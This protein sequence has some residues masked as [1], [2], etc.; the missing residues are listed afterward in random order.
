MALMDDLR[1]RIVALVPPLTPLDLPL[2][3]AGGCILH[4]GVRAP[5]PVPAFDTVVIEGFAVRTGAYVTGE[6][7]LMI[8]DVPAGFRASE[9]IVEGTCI[10]VWPGAPLPGGSD[11]VVE[12]GLAHVDGAVIRLPLAEAGHGYVRAGSQ[13]AEGAVIAEPGEQLTPR[14]I[15]VLARASIRSVLVH[16][17]PRVLAVTMGTEYVEPGVPTPIGLVADHLSFPVTAIADAAGAI[18][19]RVPPI[20]GEAAE[21]VSIV[22]DSLHRTDVIVVCGVGATGRELACASLGLDEMYASGEAGCAFG[23][24]EGTIILTLGAGLSEVVDLGEILLP[25][26]IRAQ[27]GH[28]PSRG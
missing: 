22:D 2:A 6:P 12:A 8:D 10:R 15:G 1:A 27:M 3:D 4:G 26:I 16:P 5:A 24:R 11:A 9:E 21:L 23:E 13:T 17:R 19:F 20:L 25:A 14:L 18:A 28:T 7:L